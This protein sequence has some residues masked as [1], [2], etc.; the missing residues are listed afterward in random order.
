MDFQRPL[1]IAAIAAVSFML[2]LEWNKY[3]QTHQSAMNSAQQQL[4]TAMSSDA[5]ATP[6]VAATTG[7]DVPVPEVPG[8]QV[9]TAAAAVQGQLVDVYT[10]TLQVKID[11]NGGDLV[12]VALRHYPAEIDK[13]DQPFV[14]LTRTGGNLY[15]AQSGLIG[16]NGIDK[17]AERPRYRVQQNRYELADGSNELAVDLQLE[18]SNGISITKRYLF[19]R[20]E[21]L[22]GVQ[23]LVQNRSA[24]PW[25]AHLYGQIKRD[26]HEPPSTG[27]VGLKPFLGAATTTAEKNYYKMTFDDMVD[28]PHKETVKGGWIAMVQHYFISAWVPNA[29]DNNLSLIHI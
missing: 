11:V 20:G 7:S 27:A 4:A 9:A 29:G 8:A 13:P 14:M 23:Y 6:E 28:L 24:Q 1:L 15:V 3:Q 12:M 25:S 19:T 26:R 5:P 2:L 21:H 18:D 17:S 10:D 22:I 16:D